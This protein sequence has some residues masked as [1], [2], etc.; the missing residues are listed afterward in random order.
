MKNSLEDELNSYSNNS[1]NKKYIWIVLILLIAGSGIY[2]YLMDKNIESSQ[3]GYNTKKV[4]KGDVVVSVTATGNLEPT[5]SVDIGIEVS[6]TLKEIYVDFNDRVEVGQVLAKIDT[7][8]LQAKVD[9]SK[10]SLT[11]AKA[12]LI[13]SEVSLKN[14]KVNYDRILKMHRES[15]GKYP[16]Q[17]DVDD[18]MFSYESAKAS[19][20][21]MKA[22]VLQAQ[23]DLKTD[24]EN[25][26]KAVVKSSINGIVLDRVVEVGQTVAA[27]NTTPTLF[28]VAK[29]LRKMELIVNIDEADVANI[30]ENL[31]VEFTVDAY[32]DE[33]FKGKIRQVRYNPIESSGVITYE[34]V[35]LLNNDKL[36]LRPG[37]TATAQ[38]FTKQ[39]RDQIIVPNAA[40]RFK[41]SN[42]EIRSNKSMK[43]IMS[44][45][46]RRP[47][48][49]RSNKSSKNIKKSTNMKIVYVLK[50]GEAKSVKVKTIDTDGKFTAIKSRNLSVGDEV[51]ISQS[52][53]NE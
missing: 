5:N 2:Y 26:E 43:D 36:L 50:D 24:E 48:G 32:P 40:F 44:G 45:S 25:L 21:A 46:G 19:L 34:T 1:G 31:D 47:K 7:A 6:G 18:A 30:K 3:V 17:N 22:K 11:I 29:D 41:P 9:S 23:Y 35:V 37:M 27:T 51:I 12:N 42:K 28:T 15:G 52:S 16:S 8:K 39:L 33:K 49:S 10:A 4:E 13:E 14:K 38:I 20:D 53:I